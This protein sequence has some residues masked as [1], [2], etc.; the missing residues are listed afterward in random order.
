MAIEVLMTGLLPSD[1]PMTGRCYS[2]GCQVRCLKSDAVLQSHYSEGSWH[3]VQC[4]T[5]GC[6]GRITVSERAEFRPFLG[7]DR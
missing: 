7:S 4:P 2:C 1:R 5:D 6:G 3:E